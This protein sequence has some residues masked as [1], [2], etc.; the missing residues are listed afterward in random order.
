MVCDPCKVDPQSDGCDPCKV[1]PQSD[2]CDPC[3]VYPQSDGCVEPI[4]PD[5][6]SPDQPK[7]VPIDP[8]TPSPDQPKVVPIDPDTPSPDQ[9]EEIYCKDSPEDDEC[10]DIVDTRLGGEKIPNQ[11]LVLLKNYF[12]DKH[13]ASLS[14]L[15]DLTA[16]VKNLGVEVLDVYEKIIPGF[17]IRAPNEEILGNVL[18]I[19]ENDSRIGVLEQDQTIVAFGDAVPNGIKRVDGGLVKMGMASESG[20]IGNID[21]DIAIIDSGID[22]DNPELNIFRNTTVVP[23]TIT[24]DD[25]IRCGGH[26]THVAGIASSEGQWYWDRRS[27]PRCKVMGC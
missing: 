22:L 25:D 17:A 20:S 27:S 14:S 8:D 18:T 24:A 3:K 5:T 23:N 12:A 13:E 2:G 21:I 9:P 15:Q 10:I 7:V 19:L 6:P 26:G 16:K 11:Y 1:D 4:D